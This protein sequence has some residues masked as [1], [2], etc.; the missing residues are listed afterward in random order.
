MK[1]IYG[2]DYVYADTRLRDSIVMHKGVPVYVNGVLGDGSCDVYPLKGGRGKSYMAKLD[3]LDVKPV[4]LG[5]INF[6]GRSCYVMRMPKRRDWKQGLRGANITSIGI[7]TDIHSI[8]MD[9]WERVILG[10][11][12]SFQSCV[13]GVS[14]T[15]VSMA[16]NRRWCVKQDLS[17]WYKEE[18][19]GEVVDGKPL[20]TQDYQ[21][22]NEC[23]RESM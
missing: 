2:N 9:E 23:L 12:P 1:S 10:N 20:L 8:P 6:K 17:L 18:K 16:W 13:R 22:L 3:E 19:V 15:A 7:D 21:H 4:K 14:S 5:Y 11:Y